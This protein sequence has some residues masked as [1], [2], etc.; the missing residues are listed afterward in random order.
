MLWIEKSRVQASAKEER[1]G[2]ILQF[3]NGKR[4]TWSKMERKYNPPGS[5]ASRELANSTERKN[6][7][8]PVCGVKEFVCMS[9]LNFNPN[10]LR[11]GITEWAKKININKKNNESTSLF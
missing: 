9:V 6:L 1:L 4:S 11:T 2:S 3:D 5:K 7:H 8:T 10:Y